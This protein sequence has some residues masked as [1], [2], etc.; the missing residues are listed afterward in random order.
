MKRTRYEWP[1]SAAAA[2]LIAL[3]SGCTVLYDA[4]DPV[5]G[6]PPGANKVQVS[7][8][9]GA[10]GR[11]V[12]EGNREAWLYCRKGALVDRFILAVF[13]DSRL[14]TVQRQREFEFG[15]CEQSMENFTLSSAGG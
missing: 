6:I 5:A 1:R 4:P 3:F 8:A 15:D 12:V 11:I 7:A 13:K 9:L 14:E 10:P 2:A